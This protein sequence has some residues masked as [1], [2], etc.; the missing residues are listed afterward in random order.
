MTGRSG[1]IPASRS[2][3]DAAGVVV[4]PVAERLRVAAPSLGSRTCPAPRAAG[5]PGEGRA[6]RRAGIVLDR[7]RDAA[8][9]AAE[10]GG[11]PSSAVTTISSKRAG[12]AS[13]TSPLSNAVGATMPVA[14]GQG[15]RDQPL[16]PP[17]HRARSCSMS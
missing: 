7:H 4:Q 8:H 15:R 16:P 5:H 6:V 3:R 10:F 17:I 14:C 1:L 13:I 2:D 11:S 9:Q 12:S